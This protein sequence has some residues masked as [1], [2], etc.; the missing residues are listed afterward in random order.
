MRRWS[1]SAM[2]LGLLMI[3]LGI[4]A[5]QAHWVEDGVAICTALDDQIIP[6]IAP[7]GL[8]G[9]LITWKDNRNGNY[10]IFAQRVDA[11]GNVQWIA[12]GIDICIASGGQDDPVILSDGHGGAIITWDDYRSDNDVYAQRVDHWGNVKWS[13]GGILIGTGRDPCMV[14]DGSGGAIIAWERGA[15][16]YAQRID[17]SGTEL[18]TAGGVA[19]CVALNSQLGPA[20]SSDEA[21]GAVIS[22]IDF[23]NVQGDI[24]A[25]RVDSSGT[26]QWMDDGI[27]ICTAP[28]E[29][30]GFIAITSDGSGGAI[31][32]WD[33][34]RSGTHYDIYAQ[35]I[36]GSGSRP[37]PTNGVPIC[38]VSG[39]KYCR[40]SCSDGSGGAIITWMDLRTAD[41]DIYAQA[42]DTS[43]SVRWTVDGAAI[44]VAPNSQG[45]PV[46]IPDGSGGAIIVWNDG[47]NGNTDIYAQKVGAS[48]SMH[49]TDNGVALSTAPNSQSL[50]RIASDGSGGAITTWMDN[51]SGG[52]D[53]YAQRIE[54]DGR[55]GTYPAPTI[56]AVQ[57]VPKDQGGKM[58]LQWERSSVDTIPSAEISH[59][60]VWRRI[61]KTEVS[62]FTE[63]AQD[64][65]PLGVTVDFDG[66]A[67]R[68]YSSSGDSAWEWLA[69]VPARH[70]E[71]YALTVQSL[72]DSM[73]TDPGWQYFMIS[74]HTNDP[75]VYYD[76][77]VDSGYSV[78]DLSPCQPEGLAGEAIYGP[79]GLTLTREPDSESNLTCRAIY[80]GDSKAFSPDPGNL[81]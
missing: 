10:D 8:G 52:Y 67:I 60:S 27:P 32:A 73:G 12:N 66:P 81:G 3:L 36:T 28:D 68:F 15:D 44:C 16:I 64:I 78:D 70:F 42:I 54:R 80:R 59:Y 61:P 26:V 69:N 34:Y 17:S 22:W 77:P 56:T 45:D 21:S 79:P 11:S 25:Q 49:W 43:G 53:I 30:T 75:V 71:T 38:T 74:A 5:L 24:Y 14:S 58:L 50:V 57:D 7:D 40:G 35:R 47:R 65:W 19:I 39:D 1:N 48:G 37:W 76:S 20:I 62:L 55:W 13:T 23:R 18:W 2:V 6:E 29:Q 41:S 33:D 63:E 46:I 9:A 31:I 4:P 51:R 72:Y